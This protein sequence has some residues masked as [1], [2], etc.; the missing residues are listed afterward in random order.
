M[1][2]VVYLVTVVGPSKGV[3]GTV[4]IDNN[5]NSFSLTL[6]INGSRHKLYSWSFLFPWEDD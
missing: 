5:N 1:D 3:R 4:T 2:L 6:R